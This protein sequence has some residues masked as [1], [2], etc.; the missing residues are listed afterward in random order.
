MHHNGLFWRIKSLRTVWSYKTT[1][2]NIIINVFFDEKDSSVKL[3]K[4]SSSLLH[5]D[6]F[7]I[8]EETRS[9][10]WFSSISISQSTYV[11]ESTGNGSPLTRSVGTLNKSSNANYYTLKTYLTCLDMLSGSFPLMETSPLRPFPQG[12]R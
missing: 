3:L 5:N 9:N 6:P 10:G 8:I 11:P 1:S 4:S 2:F 7:D 12:P